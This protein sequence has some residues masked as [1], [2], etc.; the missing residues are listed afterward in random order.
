MASRLSPLAQ[1]F[2]LLHPNQCG[3][4]PGLSFFN[5]ASTLTHVVRA[6]HNAKLK[7]SMLFLGIKEVLDNWN[8]PTL[9]SLLEG[10]GIPQTLVAGI[11]CFLTGHL[12]PL[13]VQ[14]SPIS[15]APIPVGTPFVCRNPLSRSDPFWAPQFLHCYL[16]FKSHPSTR[17]FLGPS[18]IPM[19][20]TS[21]SR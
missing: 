2:A 14:G 18:P 19:L 8:T 12:C 6:A 20:T 10:K 15:F 4:L 9:S 21:P 3:S 16:L 5:A 7:A 13:R 11:G 1:P 17:T